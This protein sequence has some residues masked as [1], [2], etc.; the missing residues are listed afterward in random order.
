MKQYIVQHSQRS[1]K[2][3]SSLNATASHENVDENFVGKFGKKTLRAQLENSNLLECDHIDY[4]F[5]V[6]LSIDFKL[7]CT[8]M[9]SLKQI[10]VP[11]LFA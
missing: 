3:N 9:H 8:C 10:K 5:K 6:C 11:A 1:E 7:I 4:I 2:W